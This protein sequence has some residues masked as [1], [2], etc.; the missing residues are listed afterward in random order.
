MIRPGPTRFATTFIALGSIHHHKHDLQAL[1]TS[2]TLV[3]SRYYRDPKAR[4][5]I[6][7]VLDSRFW[8]DVE[9]VV[10]L[11]QPLITLLRIVDGDDRPSLPYVYDG[12]FRA[13]RA[14]KS[15]FMNKRS[16]YKPYTRI[17]KQ[18]W[19][20]HLRQK[21]HDAAYVLNPSFFYDQNNMSQKSEV[22]AGFLH[23]LTSQVE[24][25]QTEFLSATE[26][27]REKRW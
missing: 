16:L 2:K 24:G 9:V 17:I 19:D 25:N 7:V 14:I 8:N 10:R 18:R 12:M 3:D 20:K 11:V 23:V 1:V 15:I 13:K 4:G 26:R 21:L 27:Y 22:M 5:F 6:V